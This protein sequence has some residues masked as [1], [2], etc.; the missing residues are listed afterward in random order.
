MRTI[1]TSL[2]ALSILALP[3]TGRGQANTPAPVSNSMPQNNFGFNLPTHLGTL[4]YSVSG[5]EMLEFGSEQGSSAYASTALS[6]NLA[7]MSPSQRFPFSMIYSGGLVFTTVPGNSNTET[8]QDIAVSQVANFKSWVFV[9]SDSLSFLPGSP[10]TGLSGYAGVGD[11]GVAPV[12]TG[13]GPNQSILTNYSNRIGNGLEGSATWQ[14]TPS[15]DLEASGS[16][17]VLHFTGNV[18]A[19]NTNQISATAGPSYRIDARNSVGAAAYYSDVTYPSYGEYKIETEGVNI[20]YNRAWTRKLSTTFSFGPAR[21]HGITT[22][23]IPQRWNLAGSAQVS[24]ATRT[25]GFYGSY[26]RS[27]NGGSGIIF[28]ALTDSVAVGMERPINRDWNLGLQA[29]YSRSV[30]LIPVNGLV[31][32][33]NSVFGGAQVSRRISE[34]LSCYGSYTVVWQ[35]GKNQPSALGPAFNG[36]NNIFGFGITF[37]PAPLLSGR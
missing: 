6:G 20:N 28:G 30:G 12:Q 36:T 9:V 32:S 11:V 29:T 16:W 26:D 34:S 5:S 33:Y 19:V 17:Q 15:L 23:A 7:Y 27:V 35:S 14:A 8:F 24:Y 2:L 25:T 3:A 18:D 37:A 4:D 21:T 10:T 1:T 22:A 31:P 13:I